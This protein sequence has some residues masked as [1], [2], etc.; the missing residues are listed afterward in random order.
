MRCSFAT[1]KLVSLIG[2]TLAGGF[3]LARI[4]LSMYGL[5]LFIA[6]SAILLAYIVGTGKRVA[7]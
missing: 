1:S 6:V 3:L 7:P 2:V 4:L 5:T